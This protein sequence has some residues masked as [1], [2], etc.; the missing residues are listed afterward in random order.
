MIKRPRKRPSLGTVID[1]F[2]GIGGLTHGFVQEGFSVEIGIDI[3]PECRYPYEENNGAE[4]IE[5]NIEDVTGRMLNKRFVSNRPKI[6]VGCAPCQPF[7]SYNN[8]ANNKWRLLHEFSRL[9]EETNPNIISME[10]VPRLIS[11]RKGRLFREFIRFLEMQGYYVFWKVVCC[12]DYGV[13]QLRRRLV[14]LASNFG[15]IELIPPTYTQE[16]YKTVAQ[17]ISELPPLKAGETC[18]KDKLHQARNLS[19]KNLARIQS[20]TPGGT[21]KDWNSSLVAKC[22]KKQS[23]ATYLGVYGRMAWDEPSPTITTQC[24][25]FGNGRFGHP[26]QDRAISLREAALLQGF[27]KEYELFDPA[28]PL[29]NSVVARFLGNAVPVPLAQAIAQSIS[30]HIEAT[31]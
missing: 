30:S 4:Y 27:P 5:R 25:G 22:H 19:Q 31:K 24:T 2:C 8:K 10:N 23:G 13:P 17:A 3:D 7:S 18:S 11:F 12:A 9:I 28:Y 16:S 6:L 29:F 1:L 20:S 15:K 14:L 26:E 21:W